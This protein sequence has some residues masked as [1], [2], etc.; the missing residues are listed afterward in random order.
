[1]DTGTNAC[2]EA[3]HIAELELHEEYLGVKYGLK[4]LIML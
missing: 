3:K 1:M 4:K 2:A